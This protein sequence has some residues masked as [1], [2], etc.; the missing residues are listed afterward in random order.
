MR[1]LRRLHYWLNRRRM[2]DA[3]R[4]EMDTH[5]AMREAA[6]AGRGLADPK[7]ASRRALGNASLAR[8]DARDVWIWPWL[9]GLVRDAKFTLRWMRRRPGFAGTCIATIA[10]GTG[11]LASVLS[12]VHVVL[13]SP[14]PYP[15]HARIVQIGQVSKGRLLDEVSPAEVV[16]LAQHGGAIES[17]TMAWSSS[18][19]LSG[20]S[21]PERGRMV[22][23]DSRAFTMLGTPPEIGHC[24]RVL[25]RVSPSPEHA[26]EAC[27]IFDELGMSFWST[28]VALR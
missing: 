12:V 17:V 9:D 24:H 19:S 14:P 20:G 6:M 3:L 18:V 28:R 7:A 4:E 2:E 13:L 1:W 22:F 23:T 27:R 11:A 10:I 21:L 5:R 15:N 16:A 8:D 25:A 26:S